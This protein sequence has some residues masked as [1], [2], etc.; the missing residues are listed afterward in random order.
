MTVLKDLVC[1]Q[2]V[3]IITENY[4]YQKLNENSVIIRYRFKVRLRVFIW[5]SVKS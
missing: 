4:R 3:L 1:F 5:F 2:A